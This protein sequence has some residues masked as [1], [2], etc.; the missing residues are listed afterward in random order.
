MRPRKALVL[1]TMAAL[2]CGSSSAL[3]QAPLGF[4]PAGSLARWP[5][6]R[7]GA[8][9]PGAD[10]LLVL[11]EGQ[12]LR[13]YRRAGRDAHGD[14]V[15]DA[16]LEGQD[17]GLEG[18]R[19]LAV[20]QRFAEDWLLFFQAEDAEGPGLYA[21]SDSGRGRPASL[22]R[23]FGGRPEARAG[24][25]WRFLRLGEGRAAIVRA[26]P[27]ILEC[28]LLGASPGLSARRAEDLELPP[29]LG[30]QPKLSALFETAGSLAAVIEGASGSILLAM[31]PAAA[32]PR[33]TQPLGV[34]AL[35]GLALRGVHARG[36]ENLLVFGGRGQGCLLKG[37]GAEWSVERP[38]EAGLEA[39]SPLFGGMAA[40]LRAGNLFLHGP[41]GSLTL[42]A[43]ISSGRPVILDRRGGRTEAL[44]HLRG[45]GSWLLESGAEGLPLARFLDEGSFPFRG[46]VRDCLLSEEGGGIRIETGRAGR[47]APLEEGADDLFSC[48][49]FLGAEPLV[50]AD[51]SQAQGEELLDYGARALMEGSGGFSRESLLAASLEAGGRAACIVL[52]DGRGGALI[53]QAEASE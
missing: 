29:L 7:S 27:G 37:K 32:Q 1:T 28:L 50:P 10:P 43:D 34:D 19:G 23:V 6:G 15:Q 16:L 11:E 40:S 47:W 26:L 36:K 53:F 18:F 14:W 42:A 2:L 31:D 44:L 9:L 48:L 30:P 13:F 17:W 41:A 38:A 4:L 52:S 24:Q 3:A 8:I 46:L 35:R 21:F 12:G 45:R 25:S 49:L 5:E 20:R 22:M 51:L 33:W 39:W